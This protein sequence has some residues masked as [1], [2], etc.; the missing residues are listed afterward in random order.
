MNTVFEYK[1]FVCEEED[2]ETLLNKAG[3]EGWRLHTCEPFVVIGQ[4]GIGSLKFAV[5]LDQV[6]NESEETGQESSGSIEGIPMK[7]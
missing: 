1:A 6:Y 3:Q 7:N 4:E 2:L 5:V